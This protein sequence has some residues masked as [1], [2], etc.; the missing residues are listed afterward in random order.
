MIDESGEIGSTSLFCVFVASVTDHVKKV[1]KIVKVFPKGRRE[2]KHYNSLDKTK[3]EV[4]MELC[5]CDVDVYC[6]SYRKSKLDCDTPKKKSIHIIGQISELVELV[7][8]KD[9]DTIFDLA[10]DNTPLIDGYEDI[11]AKLCY[12]IAESC[13]KTI[14]DLHIMSSSGTNVLKIHDYVTGTIGAHIEHKKDIEH[15]CH[16][17]FGIIESK[18]KEIIER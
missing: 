1:E 6:V 16:D 11:L 17:R 12:K 4:L 3:I 10:I 13:G 14:E 9:K 15:D 5:S 7:L 18:I 2:N 8:K